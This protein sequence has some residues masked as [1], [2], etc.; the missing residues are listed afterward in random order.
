[1][2]F[3]DNFAFGSVLFQF[4]CRFNLSTVA[5]V[6]PGVL[7]KSPDDQ[8]VQITAGVLPADATAGADDILAFIAVTILKPEDSRE[9]KRPSLEND[10][11]RWIV[12]KS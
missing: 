3:R 4:E 2:R 1:M 12:A 6:R 10:F 11:W 8:V 5:F 9:T 7:N